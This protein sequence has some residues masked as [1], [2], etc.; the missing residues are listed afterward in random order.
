MSTTSTSPSEIFNGNDADYLPGSVSS[1]E[2]INGQSVYVS[3]FPGTEL[4][5]SRAVFCGPG[6]CAPHAQTAAIA[7]VALVLSL[8]S[9]ILGP[10]TSVLSVVALPVSI[11][12]AHRLKNSINRG[13]QMARASIVLSSMA[14]AMLLLVVLSQLIAN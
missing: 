11:I 6:Y 5:D 9:W 10:V 3:H 14:L 7:I 13:Q 1:R 2:T 8:L 12:A 4:V